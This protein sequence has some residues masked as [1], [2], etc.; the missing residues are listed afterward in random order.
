MASNDETHVCVKESLV[1]VLTTETSIILC[2]NNVLRCER[3]MFGT[4]LSTFFV[5]AISCQVH[6]ARRCVRLLLCSSASDY[7]FHAIQHSIVSATGAVLCSENGWFSDSLYIFP[8]EMSQGVRMFYSLQL[9]I[10]MESCFYLFQKSRRRGEFDLVMVLHHF[11]T[12]FLALASVFIG[13]TRIGIVVMFLHDVS[14]IGVDALKIVTKKQNVPHGVVAL[15]F[16]ACVTVWVLV[17]CL[18]FP[19]MLILPFLKRFGDHPFQVTSL[20]M[21]FCF[22]FIWLY[23]LVSK[24]F[25]YMRGIKHA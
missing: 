22:S 15:V 2:Y 9:G 1:G 3:S 20:I 11:T 17:R 24:G 16:C 25:S 4:E 14:D 21:L 5:F 13:T 18:C 7:V 19:L 10:Y 23:E 8:Q 12:V 6:L